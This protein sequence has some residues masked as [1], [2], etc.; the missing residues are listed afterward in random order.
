MYLIVQMHIPCFSVESDIVT[1]NT[2]KI[3]NFKISAKPKKKIE[4]LL[5]IS[6]HKP[7][8]R[9]N[10]FAS[11]NSCTI[12]NYYYAHIVLQTTEHF[13]LRKLDFTNRTGK[14]SFCL[15]RQL[16]IRERAFNQIILRSSLC[17]LMIFST[18]NTPLPN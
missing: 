2:P 3:M 8:Q 13:R 12:L 15:F 11:S 10:F 14:I 16:V 6:I 1:A 18:L 7:I 5:R 17:H 9:K 4:Y